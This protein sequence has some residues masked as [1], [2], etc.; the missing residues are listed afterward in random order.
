[1]GIL[2]LGEKINKK[3]F[4]DNELRFLSVLASDVVMA[5]KN[6]WLIEDLNRQINLNKRLLVQTISALASSIEAKDKYTIGHTGRVANYSLAIAMIL[7]KHKKIEQWDK[8]FENL[9]IAALFHD[10]GKIGI[11]ENILNKNKSLNMAER[12]IIMQH[13]II[14]ANILGHVEELREAL[15][16]VKYHHEKYDGTG[17]PFHL[18]GN[19]I[20]LIAS[21]ISLADTFDALISDRPY[22][23][24]ISA[25]EAV[26]KIKK[27][28]GNQ[29]MPCVVDAFLK[30]HRDRDF[31]SGLT[32]K[33][34]PWI[35]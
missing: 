20:P 15:E 31:F 30:M 7:H 16:G 19:K 10:I 1:V 33:K 35:P 12:K 18:K 3:E 24:A 17:Y 9:K 11:P 29:F 32:E 23:R 8:F 21:I 27:G 14:G 34:F 2:F 22:R 13:P 28:K 4:D 5:L 25:Q 6:A 26:K